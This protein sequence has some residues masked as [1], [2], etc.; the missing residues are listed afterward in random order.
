MRENY[1]ENFRI[2][3]LLTGQAILDSEAIKR[4]NSAMEKFKNFYE[5]LKLYQ[6]QNNNSNTEKV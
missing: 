1:D 2:E 4:N 3:Q 6:T 5:K